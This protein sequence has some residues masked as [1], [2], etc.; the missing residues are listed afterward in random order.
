M[1]RENRLIADAIKQRLSLLNFTPPIPLSHPNRGI[2][3]PSDGSRWISYTI[4]RA[5][6]ERLDL[7]DST[8]FSGSLVAIV[9][10]RLSAG[11]GEGE[12]LADAIAGHFPVDLALPITGGGHVRITSHP[13]V[14]TGYQD[15]AYW[16]TPVVVPFAALLT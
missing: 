5:E 2:D 14:R 8:R 3:P 7:S 4:E 10:T 11:S 13:S 16:R 15:G 1:S 12:D 9:C 6:T